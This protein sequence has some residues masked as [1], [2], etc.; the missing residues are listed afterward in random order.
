MHALHSFLLISDM[1]LTIHDN[2]GFN[3][4]L[5]HSLHFKCKLLFFCPIKLHSDLI[6]PQFM[7][8]LH[9]SLLI[10]DKLSTRFDNEVGISLKLSIN[11]RLY[12]IV[13]IVSLLSHFFNYFFF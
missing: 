3:H 8:A 12:V 11:F 9:S 13:L 6:F 7:H 2:E 1:L 5:S 10:S 4:I